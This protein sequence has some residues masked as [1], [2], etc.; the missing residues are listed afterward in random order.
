MHAHV[1]VSP[2]LA[3]NDLSAN[4]VA[5]AFAT[6]VSAKSITL[7]Q[8]V[9]IA[10]I[11]EFLG[12]LLLGA[13]VTSTIRKKMID[14]DSKSSTHCVSATF[15]PRFSH[16]LSPVY[17]DEPDVLMFGMLTALVSASFMMAVANF[18]AL[19]ISTTHTIIGSIV[20]FSIAAKGFE[21][22]IW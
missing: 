13:S 16:Q 3:L 7:K 14:G 22:V 1:H 2:S 4:D 10:A 20:G 19:P 21:S 9:I 11:C 8:A 12:A 6:S 18:F 5:N 15:S 17:A